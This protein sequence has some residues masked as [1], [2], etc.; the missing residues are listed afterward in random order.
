MI[1]VGAPY[2]GAGQFSSLVG[3]P[4]PDFELAR[5]DGDPFK[6]R[7]SLGKEVV[8]LDFWA[9]W[10]GPCIKALPD[11]MAAVNEFNGKGVRLIAVNQQ[12]AAN[13]IGQFLKAKGWD[14]D[15]V[16]DDNRHSPVAR[17]FGVTG[18]PTTFVIG[19][20]GKVSTMHSGYSPGL[21]EKLVDD[22]KR[23]MR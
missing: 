9:T 14:L 10:C 6:L 7:D 23:A 5:L 3:E 20:D 2:G 8:V 4:A 22:I 18:I 16:L 15:V 21:R 13:E 12:E 19:K 17:K 11:V 1:G